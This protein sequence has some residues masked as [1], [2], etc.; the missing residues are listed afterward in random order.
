MRYVTPNAILWVGAGLLLLAV[1]TWLFDVLPFPGTRFPAWAIPFALGLALS[2]FGAYL[3]FNEIRAA[4]GHRTA[5]YW[6]NSVVV[7]GLALGI[8]V[9]VSFL[10]IRH[11][12]RWDLTENRR[13]SLSSQTIKVLQSLATDVDRKS[14]V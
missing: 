13:N 14:V 8:V 10:G 3:K 2:A 5:R 4:L 9:L 11:A 6:F 12:Y 7:V 1:V